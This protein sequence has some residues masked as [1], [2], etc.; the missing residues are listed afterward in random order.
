MSRKWQNISNMTT[1]IASQKVILKHNLQGILLL[2]IATNIFARA[3]GLYCCPSEFLQRQAVF[4]IKWRKLYPPHVYLKKNFWSFIIGFLPK[5]SIN[6]SSKRILYVLIQ[7]WDAMH[8]ISQ[9]ILKT[10][11][12][13]FDFT[14][15]RGPPNFPNSSEGAPHL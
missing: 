14:V 11:K 10:L 9:C 1:C 5:C 13:K 4:G 6:R 12:S 2:P 8:R 7:I 3:A 15:T